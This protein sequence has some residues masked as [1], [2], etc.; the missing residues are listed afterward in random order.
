MTLHAHTYARTRGTSAA[1]TAD[2]TGG[3]KNSGRPSRFQPGGNVWSVSHYRDLGYCYR[4]PRL[5][6]SDYPRMSGGDGGDAAAAAAM[7]MTAEQLAFANFHPT[8]DL[9]ISFHAYF[10]HQPLSRFC[11]TRQ[12]QSSVSGTLTTRRKERWGLEF[13]SFPQCLPNF[14]YYVYVVL[15]VLSIY[16]LQNIQVFI[17]KV[18][19]ENLGSLFAKQR[20]R[21]PIVTRNWRYSLRAHALES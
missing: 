17:S 20:R 11:L 21:Q 5:I 1:A 18:H 8:L 2:I 3:R 14:I 4:W 13:F 16:I 10:L 19:V 15:C 12:W 6:F 7:V 9:S